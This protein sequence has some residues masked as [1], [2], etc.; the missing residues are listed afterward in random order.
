MPS[1]LL[2]AHGVTHSFGARAVLDSVDLSV[3]EGDRIALVGRNGSGKSTLLRILVGEEAPD[4]GTVARHGSVA[5][6]PQLLATPDLTARDAIL[7]RIGVAAATRELDRQATALAARRPRRDRR[8]RR[9]AGA[10]ARPRRRG[11]RGTARSAAATE[12]GLAP[13]AARPTAR[14]ASPAGRPRAPGSPPSASPAPT[15]SSSTS[16]PTTSTPTASPAS[17]PCSP[18]TPARSSSSPTTAP[19]SATSPT[20]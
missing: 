13:D 7:E 18:N 17:A 8:S 5:Y 12:L 1:L 9:R 11:R 14:P 19:C 2:D 10:L 16:R 15:C 20:R 4:A 3:H 6:L